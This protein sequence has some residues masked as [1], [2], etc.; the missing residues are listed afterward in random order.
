MDA[1]VGGITDVLKLFE[2]VVLVLRRGY[3]N[4]MDVFVLFLTLVCLCSLVV[5]CS[6]RGK[7]EREKGN[8]I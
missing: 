2:L 8:G 7:H 6:A 3:M 1:I 5:G 4:L